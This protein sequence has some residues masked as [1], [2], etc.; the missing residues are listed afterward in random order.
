MNQELANSLREAL[1]LIKSGKNKS[2]RSILVEILKTHPD[3]EQAWYMM[4]FA[5]PVL[6]KQIYSLEQVLRINPQNE[7]AQT[8]LANLKDQPE[9]TQQTPVQ[10]IEQVESPPPKSKKLDPQE[11]LL[12]Q[13]LFGT[14]D[15]QDEEEDIL[16]S[17]VEQPPISDIET[18]GG[19]KSKKEKKK[20]ER[21]PKKPKTPREPK[22]GNMLSRIPRRVLILVVL[23]VVIGALA[24]SF[25]PGTQGNTGESTDQIPSAPTDPPVQTPT[26]TPE[27]T[28]T[29]VVAGGL[30]P[31]WTPEQPTPTPG[32]FFGEQSM[33][34][35]ISIPTPS[36]DI[37]DTISTIQE[38]LAELRGFDNSTQVE[39]FLVTSTIYRSLISDFSNFSGYEEKVKEL[40]LMFRALGL[41]NSGDSLSAFPQNIWADPDGSVFLPDVNSVIIAG[42]DLDNYRK[43]LY[44]RE[45]SQVIIDSN[46]NL[47][48]FGVFPICTQLT[49]E[50][51]A[52]LAL[53]KGESSFVAYKWLET[54][55]DLDDASSIQNLSPEYLSISMQSPP[56]FV[57]EE[58][59]FPYV[60]GLNFVEY[61]YDSGGWEAVESA[62]VNLPITTEQILHPEK[63]LNAE[64]AIEINDLSLADVLDAN[65]VKVMDGSLG[66]WKTYLVLAHGVNIK[67]QISSEVA[68]EAA[69]G[70]GGDQ[71]QIFFNE[72][73]NQFVVSSHWIWD[74]LIDK[75]QFYIAFSEFLDSRYGTDEGF[76]YEGLFCW[77]NSSGVSCL[78]EFEDNVLWLSAPD[79][80][81]IDSIMSLYS[82][83]S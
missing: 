47:E 65:W 28:P 6:E 43:F 3:N 17:D 64:D 82:G 16:Q 56:P 75:D 69:A 37:L 27:P 76:E 81:V 73:D 7:K 53:I 60:E 22:S 19:K 31:T 67:A 46:Y 24:L 55:V 59:Q 4:S 39:I 23:V 77:Q 71:T 70:W 10:Q 9:I 36:E 2:A 32:P 48:S 12:A 13:R 68:L 57:E 63:Y 54:N 50:C 52:T 40:E 21:K 62:Y 25:L 26:K 74:T 18:E 35:V 83:G 8:R 11:D 45:Y 80:N 30:P 41:S 61:L 34:S 15:Q 42:Y 1:K 49:Q 14:T 5:I 58:I 20:R 33:Y 72:V 29:K 38:E 44:A 79:F 51:E 78:Q 66:E